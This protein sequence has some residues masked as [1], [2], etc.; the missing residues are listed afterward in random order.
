RLQVPGDKSISHR[1]ALLASLARGRSRLVGYAPGA[2]CA[3]TLA[4]LRHLGVE[5][6]V[7][8]EPAGATLSI[9]GRGLRGLT[10]P[11]IVLDAGN[12]GTTIRLLTG[13]LA[14]HP[15][16]AIITGDASLRRRPMRRV[17][18]PLS[19]MGAR[20]ETTTG[21]APLTVTGGPLKPIDFTPTVP[22][23]QVKSAV[24][25]AGLQAEGRTTV[26]EPVPTR[27]HTELALAAFGAR[28]ASGADGVAVEGCQELEPVDTVIPG[29]FSSAAFWAVAAAALPGSAVEITN[30]GLNPSRTALLDVLARA[31]AEVERLPEQSSL[32]E[33]R[34]SVRVRHGGLRPLVLTPDDVPGLIDE[35]PALAAMAAMGG[36]LHVTGAGELRVKESDRISALATGLRA[37][38]ADVEEFPD[39]FHVRGGRQLTGGTADA[40][41]DHRLAM[42]FAVA[43]LAA[44]GP[45]HITGAGAVDVSYPGFFETLAALVRDH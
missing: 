22:S 40:A 31:G 15:F 39:G 9:R 27:N 24:L 13:V 2:D 3:S 6:E 5:V 34:G 44:S 45:T 38:G 10:A 32:G 21:C 28:V 26:H 43:G 41:H 30:V 11:G 14:A 20:F 37:L 17:I 16:T 18:E 8:P 35:L 23:A 42:A 25:L 36:D 19:R 33:P 29:D 1:Y 12:S 7:A 4:C